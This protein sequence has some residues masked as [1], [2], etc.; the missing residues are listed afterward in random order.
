MTDDDPLDLGEVAADAE[1]LEALRA[2]R[3]STDVPGDPALA[4]LHALLSDVA[5]DLPEGD[6]QAPGLGSSVLP[7]S[8]DR[9]PSRRG[10]RSGTAAALVAAGVLS[11]G[12]VAAASTMAPAGSP[13]H[14]LGQAVRAAAGA[15]V[16][17]VTPPES[18]RSPQAQPTSSPT[19]SAVPSPA[20]AAVSAGSRSAAA[21][22][23]VATHLDA[24]QAHLDAGRATQAEQRLDVAERRL[25]EVLPSDGA[26]ALADRLAALRARLAE[27]DAPAAPGGKPTDKPGGKPADKAPAG[28][29]TEKPGG[30]RDP[31]SSKPDR[32]TGPGTKPTDSPAKR[33]QTPGGSGSGGGEQRPG[34]SS[35]G[36]SSR[37]ASAKP[38]A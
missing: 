37:D 23:Q 9:P 34:Q 18:S 29:P 3:R 32:K 1:A 16:T 19:Q 21:A 2:G 30:G 28:K 35:S 15:V 14:D 11:L 26:Q 22:R 5:G 20:G 6:A 10:L 36:Q 13:L 38:R 17:A 31:G 7:L 24:A 12:G 33:D 25:P 27:L 4:A 8:G